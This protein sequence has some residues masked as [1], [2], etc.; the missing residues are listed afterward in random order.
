MTYINSTR[1][2]R[3][4]WALMSLWALLVLEMYQEHDEEDATLLGNAPQPSGSPTNAEREARW[5]L[6]IWISIRISRGSVM[7]ELFSEVSSIRLRAFLGNALRDVFDFASLRS[8]AIG[9]TGSSVFLQSYIAL[10][11]PQCCNLEG[12]YSRWKKPRPSSSPAEAERKVMLSLFPNP[13]QSSGSLKA[14]ASCDDVLR[15]VTSRGEP[16]SGEFRC[17]SAEILERGCR[18]RRPFRSG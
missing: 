12:P 1:I 8:P 7:S 17:T 14:R 5:D 18:S 6:R 9:I 3:A 2:V 16:L 11:C 4:F 15:H 10:R 13:M